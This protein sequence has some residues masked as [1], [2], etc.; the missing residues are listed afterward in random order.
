VSNLL[1][2]LYVLDISPL[3][4]VD[5]VKVVSHSVGCH[6]FLLMVSFA[7]QKLQLHYVSVS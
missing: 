4:D 2:S 6:F 1:S 7:L 5:S 3:S